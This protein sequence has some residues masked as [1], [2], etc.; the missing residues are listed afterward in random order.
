MFEVAKTSHNQT[1]ADSGSDC[2]KT[3]F[4]IYIVVIIISSETALKTT[5]EVSEIQGRVAQWVKALQ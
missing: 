5:G 3:V 4:L 2:E 1:R